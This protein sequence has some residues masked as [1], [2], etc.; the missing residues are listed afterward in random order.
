MKIHVTKNGRWAHK[1]IDIVDIEKGP[2]DYEE[3]LANEL[4]DNGWAAL[5]VEKEPEKES[6]PKVEQKSRGWWSV[7]F[8]GMDDISVRGAE[9]A[10]D[11]IEMAKA[12]IEAE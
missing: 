6:F 3:S 2:Q 10:E 1:G 7:T 8:D 4:L 9:D 5:Y 12:K 11:A